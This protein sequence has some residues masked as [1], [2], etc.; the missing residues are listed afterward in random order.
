MENPKTVLDE[1][2]AQWLSARSGYERYLEA[3]TNLYAVFTEGW[4]GP[5][6]A[7]TEAFTTFCEALTQD[8]EYSLLHVVEV[9]PSRDRAPE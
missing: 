9:Y 3:T 5:R 1:A 2:V 7:L 4:P 6:R 8:S